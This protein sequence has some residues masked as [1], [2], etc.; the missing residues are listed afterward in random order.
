MSIIARIG[1]F[2]FKVDVAPTAQIADF[3]AVKRRAACKGMFPDCCDRVRNGYACEGRA[4]AECSPV[5]GN[6]RVNAIVVADGVRDVHIAV[7]RIGAAGDHGMTANDAIINIADFQV[8][9]RANLAKF[10]KK[11]VK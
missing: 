6:D 11:A 8:L 9:S 3:H 5:D 4:L 7:I 2:G 1:R 10:K